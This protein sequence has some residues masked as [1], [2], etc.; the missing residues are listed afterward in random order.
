MEIL[1]KIEIIYEENTEDLACYL[2]NISE[3]ISEIY[4]LKSEFVRAEEYLNRQITT[5]I[6]NNGENI[7]S[8]VKMYKKYDELNKK[9]NNIDQYIIYQLKQVDLL[10]TN[11]TKIEEICNI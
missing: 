9:Q 10:I 4:V 3:K 1:F 8:V 5:F 2:H 11:K 6:E 7:Y